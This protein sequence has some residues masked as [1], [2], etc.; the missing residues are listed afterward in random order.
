MIDNMH[1]LFIEGIC[2]GLQLFFNLAMDFWAGL[3]LIIKL[4]ALVLIIIQFSTK[5][6]SN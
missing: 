3:P 1:I 5:K 4:L 2:N 6:Y